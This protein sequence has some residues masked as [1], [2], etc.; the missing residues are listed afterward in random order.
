MADV[1]KGEIR[2]YRRE[3][4]VRQIKTTRLVGIL[5][6][7]AEGKVTLKPEQIASARILLDRVLPTLS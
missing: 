1:P 6:D 2:G 3:H 7:A 4:V 5:Q